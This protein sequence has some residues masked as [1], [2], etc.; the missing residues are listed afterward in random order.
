MSKHNERKCTSSAKNKSQAILHTFHVDQKLSERCLVE[1][2]SDEES[3][4]VE[5]DLNIDILCGLFDLLEVIDS[6][7]KVD[8]N[9]TEF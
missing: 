5:H 9:G 6:R 4:I 7:S 3:G 1:K 2:S 8:A